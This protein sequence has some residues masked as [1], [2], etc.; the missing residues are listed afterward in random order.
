M[1]GAQGQADRGL[2]YAAAACQAP[3]I[4]ARVLSEAQRGD[5]EGDRQTQG[6]V[7]RQLQREIARQAEQLAKLRLKVFGES[8]ERLSLYPPD[9][10]PGKKPKRGHGPTPQVKLPTREVHH[11]LGDN[12]RECPACKGMLEGMGEHT[13]DTEEI[14]VEKRRF[15]MDKHVR[16]T[17]RYF[18]ATW[19]ID[20]RAMMYLWDKRHGGH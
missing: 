17:A 6:A 19:A 8:T 16:N 13:E 4:G 20:S 1:V 3:V 9:A 14:T 15:V 10:E 12:E 2:R 11:R 18:R 7:P 5:G